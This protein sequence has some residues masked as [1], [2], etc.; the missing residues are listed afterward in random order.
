M[1][2]GIAPAG[3]VK[4]RSEA[5]LQRSARCVTMI[6]EYNLYSIDCMNCIVYDTAPKTKRLLTRDVPSRRNAF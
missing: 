4:H 2:Y 6:V 1:R 5:P 3:P